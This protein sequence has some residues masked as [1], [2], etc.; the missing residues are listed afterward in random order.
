MKTTYQCPGCTNTLSIGEDIV[1]VAK[2]GKGKKGLV[3]LHTELG[4]YKTKIDSNLVISK[5]DTVKFYCP[6][7]G[8]NLTINK[9]E[10]LATLRRVDE[11]EKIDRVVFSQVYGEQCTYI[12]E[13]SEV[14]EH[15]GP[16]Y[17]Q[18]LTNPD[19]MML[20]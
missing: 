14:K 2:T 6:I 7:C 11:N 17:Y 18:Y 10:K 5:G 13:E 19:W 3:M 8:E 16:D 9:Y 12:V 4:N 20:L 15:F 1:L